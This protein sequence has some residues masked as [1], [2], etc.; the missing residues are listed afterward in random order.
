[1]KN[2]SEKQEKLIAAAP[3]LLNMIQQF[4][5]TLQDEHGSHYVDGNIIKGKALWEKA[6][7]EVWKDE[8]LEEENK[9]KGE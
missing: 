2:V 4:I 5:F 7:G 8:E 6:S 1:M 9:D 3:E